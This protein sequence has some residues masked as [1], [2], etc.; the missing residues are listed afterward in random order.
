MYGYKDTW[1][2]LFVPKGDKRTVRF[3]GIK[4]GA[5]L[6]KPFK[7]TLSSHPGCAMAKG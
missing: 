4:E 5:D 1:Q 2:F 6:T 3:D 7:L